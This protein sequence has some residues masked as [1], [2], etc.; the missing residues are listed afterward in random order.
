MKLDVRY[1]YGNCTLEIP[2]KAHVSVLTPAQVP[3]LQDI[4]GELTRALAHPAGSRTLD[5]LIRDI[6]PSRVALAVPDETRPTPLKRILPTLLGQLH[7]AASRFHLS[8][9]VQIL[10]GGGLHAPTTPE[11]MGRIIPKEIMHRWPVHP[12]DAR[13]ARMTNFGHT[14]RGTPVRV[15]AMIGEADLRIIVGQIDPHQFVGYTGGAKGIVIGC[16]SAGTIEANHGLMLHPGAEVGL[17]EGNPVREDID[18]AGRLVG[19]HMVVDVV[20]DPQKRPVWIG[21]GAPDAVLREGSRICESLY[22]IPLQEQFDIV[23]ASCGGYPKDI[24]LYQA[25]K[26][27]YH[28]SMAVKPGGKILLLAACPQG[29]GDDIYFDYVCQF[30]T[31]KELLED[32]RKTGFRMGAHKA[33]LFGRTLSEFEVAVASDLDTRTLSHCH[34]RAGDPNVIIREWVDEFNGRPRLAVIPNANTTFFHREVSSAR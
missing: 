22:G 21:A 27:L 11:A 9:S 7:R 12:H 1:G 4:D 18:E 23:V 5:E 3:P 2:Q 34:L 31:P 14:S 20:L 8:P 16:G 30:A 29:V 17:L 24:C 28:A 6:K 15:N 10:V 26:G 32:F 13:A 33:Y 19:I 25:Q